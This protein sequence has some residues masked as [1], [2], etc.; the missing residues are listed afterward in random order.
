MDLQA[1]RYAALVST[2]TFNDLVKAHS[3]FLS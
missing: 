1:I 3:E 2:M